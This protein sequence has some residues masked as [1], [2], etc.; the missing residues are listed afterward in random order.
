MPQDEGTGMEIDR[1]TKEIIYHYWG[2]LSGVGTLVGALL[3]AHSVFCMRQVREFDAM[4]VWRLEANNDP[5]QVA[6]KKI[7]KAAGW[8]RSS[9]A[10]ASAAA[11]DTG[12]FP[13][14]P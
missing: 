7:S 11:H 1:C 2:G 4:V 10:S 5:T 3:Y 9:Q 13:Y 6:T 12:A 14:N 8:N